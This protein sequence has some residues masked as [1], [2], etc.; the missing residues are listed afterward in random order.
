MKLPNLTPEQ[1]AKIK[2][3]IAKQ[4]EKQVKA[5]IEKQKEGNK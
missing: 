4:V 5:Y 2:A 1:K 3:A